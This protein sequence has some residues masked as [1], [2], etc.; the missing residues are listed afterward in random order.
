MFFMPWVASEAHRLERTSRRLGHV[1]TPV[2][3]A[4]AVRKQAEGTGAGDNGPDSAPSRRP[5]QVPCAPGLL[6]EGPVLV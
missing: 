3:Q 5:A 1:A 2:P 6:S 4:W